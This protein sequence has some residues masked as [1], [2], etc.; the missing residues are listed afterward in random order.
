MLGFVF[1]ENYIR[2]FSNIV[3]QTLVGLLL[4]LKYKEL[5][6]SAREVDLHNS[7]D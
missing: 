1:R 7:P 2:C 4:Q 5:R 3:R 6:F